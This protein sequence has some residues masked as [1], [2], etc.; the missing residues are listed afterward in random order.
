MFFLQFPLSHWLLILPHTH[1]HT[2]YCLSV[3]LWHLRRLDGFRSKAR[4]LT[5]GKPTLHGTMN[6]RTLSEVCS[7]LWGCQRA[8]RSVQGESLLKY[9]NSSSSVGVKVHPQHEEY[10]FLRCLH[11]IIITEVSLRIVPALSTGHASIRLGTPP[12]LDVR[13]D[14]KQ[15]K[16]HI[17][18][19]KTPNSTI[20]I[21]LYLATLYKKEKKKKKY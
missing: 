18:I 9:H 15:K 17:K 3:C 8:V 4:W 7:I 16:K 20:F 12:C 11:I 13:L 1:T 19:C 10:I 14:S 2:L 6:S 21:V 5:R